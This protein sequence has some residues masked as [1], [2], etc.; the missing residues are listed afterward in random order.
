MMIFYIA[1]RTEVLCTI[2]AKVYPY[3][4]PTSRRL[5]RKNL[6]LYDTPT[7]V[8]DNF[9]ICQSWSVMWQVEL[10]GQRALYRFGQSC[11]Y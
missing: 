8:G 5:I 9:D 10:Y 11:L 7:Y 4:L 1:R 6:N 3:Q 2:P